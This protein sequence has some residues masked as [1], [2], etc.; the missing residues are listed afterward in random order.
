V[1]EVLQV[2]VLLAIP[3]HDALHLRHSDS[4]DQNQVAGAHLHAAVLQSELLAAQHIGHLLEHSATNWRGLRLIHLP[5]EGLFAK[6][7]DEQD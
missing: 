5:D 7:R 4:G 3:D 2:L 1:V 6:G